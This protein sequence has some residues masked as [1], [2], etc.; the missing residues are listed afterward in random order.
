M[1]GTLQLLAHCG[2]AGIS[3]AMEISAFRDVGVVRLSFG[4]L[5]WLVAYFHFVDAL[6]IPSWG[7]GHDAIGRIGI[8]IK[9]VG[10]AMIAVS[11]VLA[12][13]IFSVAIGFAGLA[14]AVFGRALWELVFVG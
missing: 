12:V 6:W 14:T 1:S 3:L 9:S 7:A 10:F 2:L 11:A 4:V 5:F 8:A 13:S